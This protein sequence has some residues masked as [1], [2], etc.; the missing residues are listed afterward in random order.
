M[1]LTKEL[2]NIIK[3]LRLVASWGLHFTTDAYDIKRYERIRTAAARLQ[4]ILEDRPTDQVLAEVQA[5]LFGNSISPLST[6]DAVVVRDERILLIRR[7]DDGLWAL[8]GGFVAVRQ[9]LAEAALR[10]LQEETGLCGQITK[11]LGIFDSRLWGSTATAHIHHAVFLVDGGVEDPRPTPE[12][13]EV[14]FWAENDLPLLSR[15][16]HLRIPFIFKLLREEAAVPYFD[17]TPAAIPGC[18]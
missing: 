9:T 12:A 18:E 6:A 8:P 10:E 13:T 15:G 11:L 5:D 3:E 14:G 1:A 7:A 2:S 17:P 16:H 4:A